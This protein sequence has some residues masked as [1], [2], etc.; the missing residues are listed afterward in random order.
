MV[1]ALLGAS[2]P[3]WRRFCPPRNYIHYN[4]AKHGLVTD[5][6]DWRW[7][8]IRAYARQ[9]IIGREWSGRDQDGRFGD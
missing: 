6:F 7:S 2:D 9:G 4:P 3:Q 8:S 5:P 1:T